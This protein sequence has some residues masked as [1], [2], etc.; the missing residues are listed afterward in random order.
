MAWSFVAANGNQE[1]KKDNFGERLMES[2][3]N[4]A[5]GKCF[6]FFAVVSNNYIISE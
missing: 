1:Q 3:G 6:P 4:G 2:A 5:D